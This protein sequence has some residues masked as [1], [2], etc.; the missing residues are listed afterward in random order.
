M[1]CIL[2]KRIVLSGGGIRGVAHIGALLALEQKGYLK[3]VN[4]YCGV[5]AGGLISFLACIGYSFKLIARFC[6]E[7]DFGSIRNIGDDAFLNC[8]ETFGIDDG[9][10]VEKVLKRFLTEMGYAET[11]TFSQLYRLKPEAPR[12]R[13]FA[14]DINQCTIKEFSLDKT[15]TIEIITALRA[16]MSIPFYFNPVR[17]PETG[18]LLID[19]A[20][21]QGLPLFHLTPAERGSALGITFTEDHNKVNE[22]STLQDF[23]A[24]LYASSYLPLTEDIMQKYKDHL[25]VIPCGSYPMWDFEASRE[26]RKEMMEKAATAAANFVDTQKGIA[27]PRRYSVS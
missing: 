12:L 18:H 27:P 4:E 3:R 16:S 10:N 5:S 15:P 21:F 23:I 26:A 13:I 9:K 17:D 11:L 7:M 22:I 14:T 19:G 24:Q 20:L 8:L 1:R 25:I 2:P 6:L